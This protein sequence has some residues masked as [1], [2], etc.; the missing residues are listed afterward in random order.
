MGVLVDAE[1][2]DPCKLVDA[3]EV[4]PRLQILLTGQPGDGAETGNPDD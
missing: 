1:G 4:S 2:R 3:T